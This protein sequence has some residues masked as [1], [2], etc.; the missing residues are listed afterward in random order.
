MSP[1]D[2]M[3]DYYWPQ[4]HLLSMQP[5][6]SLPA[7]VGNALE[8][9]RGFA[10]RETGTYP[11]AW[12]AVTANREVLERLDSAR[13]GRRWLRQSGPRYQVQAVVDTRLSLEHRSWTFYADIY[14]ELSWEL[15]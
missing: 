2:E 5:A 4:E 10:S 1:T 6:G 9:T 7:T 11:F 12:R 3:I 14:G 8:P 13:V 15:R